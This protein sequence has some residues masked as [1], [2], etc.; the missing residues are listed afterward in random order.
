MPPP[1]KYP[2]ELRRGVR[3]ALEGEQPIAHL[4]AGSHRFA[5]CLGWAGLQAANG[6]S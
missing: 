5:S 2:D 6:N 1:K 3:I 4:E